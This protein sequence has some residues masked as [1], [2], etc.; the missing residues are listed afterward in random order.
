[1]EERQGMRVQEGGEDGEGGG[2][3]VDAEGVEEMRQMLLARGGLMSDEAAAKNR[4]REK[5]RD[6]R[7]NQKHR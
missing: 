2:E 7:F 4:E 6:E 5:K 1:M 3:D